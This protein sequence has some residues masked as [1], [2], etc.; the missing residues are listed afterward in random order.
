ME[1][2]DDGG[3]F[4]IPEGPEGPA[5]PEGELLPPQRLDSGRIYPGYNT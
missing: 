4:D 3:A 1:M 5:F 2:F